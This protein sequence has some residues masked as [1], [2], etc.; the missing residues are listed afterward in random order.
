MWIGSLKIQSMSTTT[1]EAVCQEGL[2]GAKSSS[3]EKSLYA[4]FEER[5]IGSI[6]RENI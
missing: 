2:F 3:S 1:F 6:E 4:S 5:S